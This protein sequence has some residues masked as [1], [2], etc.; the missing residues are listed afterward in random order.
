MDQSFT[1]KDAFLFY[2]GMVL[3]KIKVNSF[4]AIKACYLGIIHFHSHGRYCTRQEI[5]PTQLG[6]VCC[7]IMW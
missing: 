2:L 6:T 1:Y 7:Q 3:N 5:L 4:F